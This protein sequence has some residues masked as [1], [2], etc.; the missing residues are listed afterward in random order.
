MTN[1]TALLAIGVCCAIAVRAQ[2]P[3]QA[4]DFTVDAAT[5][6]NYSCGTQCQDILASTIPLD[7]AVNIGT[8]FDF[9][10]YNT[11]GNFPGS[12]PGD[13]LKLQAVDP[14]TITGLIPGMSSYRFQYT[15]KDLDGTAVPVTGF[16]AIPFTRPAHDGRF[17]LVAFAHGTIGVYRGCAPS[18]SPIFY[19]YDT[20]IPLLLRG[21]AVVATDYAGLGNNFTAH[22]YVSF[23]AHAHDL[24]YSV[25]AARKAFPTAFTEEWMSM[26]H[27]QG[28]GAVWK[29][30]EYPLVQNPSSGY[31]GTVALAPASK[32]Y[33]MAIL[34]EKDILPLPNF[35]DFVFTGEVAALA[36]AV[37]RVF[38]QY[39]SPW[40]GDAMKKRIELSDVGQLCSEPF[41]GLSLDLT[42]DELVVTNAN[43][44]NDKFLQQFQ[45][46][47]AP[48]QGCHASQP[49]LI[50][51]GL[52]DTSILPASTAAAFKDATKVGNEIHMVWYPGLD[53]SAVVAAASSEW[54]RFI[55]DR[56]AGRIAEGFSTNRTVKPFDLANAYKPLDLPLPLPFGI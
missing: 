45:E 16:I 51:Q 56:F 13:L 48:A 7:I 12:A 54:L 30:S 27:S 5:A 41:L 14:S 2:A 10:F 40:L 15:S 4:A 55:D 21:Y 28:G 24:Y 43:V 26:G 47:N 25:Q 29:L 35:H 31:L 33:D 1:Y 11:A 44:A 17:P 22:K 19:D 34:I 6:A 49:M 38:P 39:I 9:D 46:L 20:W 42:L 8:D 18:S 36:V 52:N 37:R 3:G 32:L 50:I 53:H 23:A